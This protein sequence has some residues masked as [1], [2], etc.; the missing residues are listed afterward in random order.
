[1]KIN[2]KILLILSLLLIGC[3]ST[4]KDKIDVTYQ[5]TKCIVY[6]DHIECS[7]T[8]GNTYY[9]MRNQINKITIWDK[10]AWKSP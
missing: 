9:A 8:D 6:Y 1:M 3:S 4:P 7:M 2:F 5:I 10:S